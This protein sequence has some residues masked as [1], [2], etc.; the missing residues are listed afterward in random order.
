MQLDLFS[1]PENERHRKLMEAT[2]RRNK[3]FGGNAIRFS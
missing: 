2:D 3:K 1:E